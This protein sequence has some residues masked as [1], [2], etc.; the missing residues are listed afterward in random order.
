MRWM[1][2]PRIAV[3]KTYLGVLAGLVAFLKHSFP[4][5]R[6]RGEGWS[7]SSHLVLLAIAVMAPLLLLAGLTI[8]NHVEATRHGL[9]QDA[10]RIADNVTANIER[11]MESALT[12]LNVLA[13]DTTFDR[14]EYHALYNRVKEGL[15]G[16]PGHVVLF[17]LDYKPLFSTRF[18]FGATMPEAPND[19]TAE[20]VATTQ[21]SL[22]SDLS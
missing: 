19:G 11:E 21:R 18:D 9:Y 4:F 17:G 5:R 8:N 7:I 6:H 12:V 22:I 2:M 14:G 13:Q 16:R 10:Q 3:S 1:K 20:K 15:K